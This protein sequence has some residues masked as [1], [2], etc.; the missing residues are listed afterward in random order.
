MN[1]LVYK[2]MLSQACSKRVGQRRRVI[3]QREYTL[4]IFLITQTEPID[5]FS[6]DPSRT[7]GITDVF[8]SMYI[9]EVYKNVTKRTFVREL[10]R[11]SK[12][13]FIKYRE[14]RD[15][16]G[17]VVIELDFRAIEKY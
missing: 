12:L 13:E 2:D 14:S 9:Q 4:L 1:R 6:D 15:D 8:E 10:L 11:L 17:E 7:L 16:G 3:N 5:P